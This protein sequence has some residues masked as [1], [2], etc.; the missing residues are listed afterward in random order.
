MN[1][2]FCGGFDDIKMVLYCVKETLPLLG[3]YIM[4][5]LKTFSLVKNCS[6]QLNF[7]F[8]LSQFMVII[9]LRQR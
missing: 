1:V 6:N 4:L 2:Y 3:M 9:D 7:S 8:S 5:W